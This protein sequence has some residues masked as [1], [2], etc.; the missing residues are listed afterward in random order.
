MKAFVDLA[1]LPRMEKLETLRSVHSQGTTDL[2][3]L[4]LKLAAEM[5]ESMRSFALVSGTF[6]GGLLVL[7]NTSVAVYQPFILLGVI[8]AILNSA[9]LYIF[10]FHEHTGD[11]ENV[12]YAMRS[13]YLPIANLLAKYDALPDKDAP[14]AEFD[15]EIDGLIKQMGNTFNADEARMNYRRRP[16]YQELFFIGLFLFSVT[17]V[18]LGLLVPHIC[19][20]WGI[21]CGL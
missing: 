13:Y 21:L 20:A 17:M 6:A 1:K 7:L 3:D 10:V 16:H 11:K 9:L 18:A 5:K 15:G 14:N 8:A 2:A 12:R 4:C 19:T